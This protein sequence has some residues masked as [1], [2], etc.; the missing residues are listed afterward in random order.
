M[1]LWRHAARSARAVTGARTSARPRF[2]RHATCG[3]SSGPSWQASRALQWPWS[4]RAMDEAGAALDALRPR[5]VTYAEAGGWGR[6]LVLEA[7]RRGIPSVGLQHG[8]I[9]RHWLNYRHGRTKCS[10]ACRRRRLSAPGPHAAV[11][12]LCRRSPRRRGHFPPEPLPLRAA[13]GSMTSRGVSRS[14]GRRARRCAKLGVRGETARRS[15]RRSLS[16]SSICG[17]RL[18]RAAAAGHPSGHQAAPGGNAG[19]YAR[20]R[21]GAPNVRSRRPRP[22]GDA[23]RSGRRR[24]HDELHRGDRRTGRSAC[25]RLSSDLPNNLPPFVDAGVMAGAAEPQLPIRRG[26]RGAAG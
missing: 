20:S 3:R 13:R 9:Y 10:P 15:S 24:H 17:A 4:A 22:I 2:S 23:A 14:C 7:R 11:R 1:A 21:T 16:R 25:P 19:A 26:A 18:G 12:R 8:F 6:A 5:R